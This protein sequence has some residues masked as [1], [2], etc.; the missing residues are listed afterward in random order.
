MV[1]PNN[2]T[3]FNNEKE[4]ATEV[5]YNMD[6]PQRHHAKWKK[7]ET[8]SY[9]V[10][11]PIYMKCSETANLHSQKADQWLPKAERKGSINY[12]WAKENV[13]WIMEMC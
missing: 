5:C 2:E 10:H 4:W 3:I 11:D 8:K 12:K 9:K 6:K 13:F 7:L 1:Y